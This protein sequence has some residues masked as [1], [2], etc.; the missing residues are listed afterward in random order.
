M[1]KTLERLWYDYLSD[2]C[3]KFDTE[4]EKELLSILIEKHEAVN[5]ELTKEQIK[6]VEKYADALSKVNVSFAKKA[7]IK[8]CEFATSFLI[9]SGNLEK[10]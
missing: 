9:E 10:T 5:K 1:K 4:E 7:F 6:L 8:G 3:G 2:E